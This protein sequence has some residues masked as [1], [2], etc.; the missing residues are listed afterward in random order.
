MPRLAGV[1]LSMSNVLLGWLPGTTWHGMLQSP[2]TAPIHRLLITR[3]R[4]RH[5]NTHSHRAA[6]AHCRSK[7]FVDTAMRIS[8]SHSVRQGQH[9]AHLVG[10]YVLYLSR[11]H[12]RVLEPRTHLPALSAQTL[13]ALAGQGRRGPC[14]SLHRR[15]FVLRACV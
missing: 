14:G 3:V 11:R 7:A 12:L 5:A 9:S 1:I 4:L 2:R 6:S 10:Q 15:S 13:T 8:E